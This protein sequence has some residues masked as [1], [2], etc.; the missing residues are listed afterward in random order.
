MDSRVIRI[1]VIVVLSAIFVGILSFAIMLIQFSNKQ[2]MSLQELTAATIQLV[3]DSEF[4]ENQQYF[5]SRPRDGELAALFKEQRGAFLELKEMVESDKLESIA[6]VEVKRKD[7]KFAIYPYYGNI[8]E[9]DDPTT[10]I[11]MFNFSK[12]RFDKY[13]LLMRKCKVAFIRSVFSE[14]TGGIEFVLW[15]DST[16]NEMSQRKGDGG[17]SFYFCDT[18]EV[19]DCE[20]TESE[21]PD[22]T[23]CVSA[24]ARLEPHWFINYEWEPEGR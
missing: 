5:Q 7:G 15:G 18:D 8:S 23:G 4:E 20:N 6:Y 21:K 11:K 10:N 12:E 9:L 22:G 1:S 17:L 16:Y 19:L 2:K 13:R 3:K 14:Y 24:F